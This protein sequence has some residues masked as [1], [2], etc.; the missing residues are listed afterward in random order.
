MP[1]ELLTYADAIQHLVDVFEFVDTTNLGRAARIAV[2]HA[3]Q[4]FPSLT[5]WNYFQRRQV[6]RT[7]A[8]QSSSTVSYDHTSGAYERVVTL[9]SGTWPSW[10]RYG[11]INIS[12]VHYRVE[13]RRSATELTLYVDDNPGEDVAAG[14]SYEIYRAAY[15]LPDDFHRVKGLI[16]IDQQ[17]D[18]SIV[19][20]ETE[21]YTSINTWGDP[22]I[23]YAANIRNTG[24]VP[25]Q[26]SIVFTPPPNGAYAYDIAY[27]ARPR[28]LNRVAWNNGGTGTITTSGATAT[29]SAGTLPDDIAGSIVRFSASGAA[30]TNKYGSNPF[31][32]ERKIFERTSDTTFTI[33]TALDS[34]LS[35]VAYSIEDPLDLR[36]GPMRTAFLRRAEAIFARL[37]SLEDRVERESAA[38]RS[39]QEAV[40]SDASSEYID[41]FVHSREMP[42]SPS[43]SDYGQEINF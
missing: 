12:G 29:I 23:P 13:E 4:E 38:H 33:E 40:Q 42:W 9:A 5:R 30:P 14:T 31:Q 1:A 20:L 19:G 41:S 34:D 18:I 35:A 43:P 28:E 21:Q 3:Y 25:G 6:F 16:D 36:P 10:A 22:D 7:S 8:P 27:E 11:R 15:P 17:R 24:E 39:L 37:R 2:D 32:A 26:M